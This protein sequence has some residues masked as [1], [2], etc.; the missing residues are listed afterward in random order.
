MK[1][2]PAS[3]SNR[4]AFLTRGVIAAAGI[5]AAGLTHPATA[6]AVTPGLKFNDIPGTGDVK[7]LN[8]ALALE[9]LEADLYAQALM[10]LTN[11]GMNALGK[12]I[13][14]LGLNPNEP[15]LFYLREFGVV[16]RQHRDFLKTALGSA[17]LLR[18]APFNRAR[19]DFAMESRSRKQV[20]DLVYLAEKT[21]VGAYLGAIKF[22]QTRT[23]LQTA[24]AIQGTEARHTAVIADVL[25]DLFN[26]PLNVAPLSNQNNGIDQPIAPDTVLASVSPFIIF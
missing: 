3:N 13:G 23:Y 4:R 10:R 26:E 8:Y 18:S 15:D 5:A 14:G 11:G 9:A 2:T 16:E 24:G 1:T 17:S 22:F 19:F 12:R 7:V 20:I 25:R 6:L 21:G